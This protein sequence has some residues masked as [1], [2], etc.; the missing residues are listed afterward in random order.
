M[1]PARFELTAPGLGNRPGA[2]TQVARTLITG[3]GHSKGMRDFLR[4]R[5]EQ[6]LRLCC[7][8]PIYSFILKLRRFP[9]QAAA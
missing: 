6:G 8:I 2:F 3:K 7:S 5:S 9:M 1:P 4:V